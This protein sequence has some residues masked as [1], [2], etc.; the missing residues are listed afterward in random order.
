MLCVECGRERDIF[1]NGVCLEC[2]LKHH[3][4]SSGP[5]FIDIPLCVHCGSMRYK[6]TWMNDPLEMV[7]KRWVKHFFYIE[8]DLRNV[9]IEVNCNLD[10]EEIP[11]EITIIGFIDGIEIREGHRVTIRLKRT[12][13]DVCSKRFGGYHEAILQ[14]RTSKRKLSNQEKEDLKKFI[15]EM[16]YSMQEKGNRKLFIA[17]VGEEHGGLD[18]YLS[19]KQVAHA[20]IKKAQDHFGGELKISSKNI[21][22]KNG[23]RIYRMTYLLR[24]FPFKKGDI[25]DLNGIIYMILSFSKNQVHALELSRWKEYSFNSKDIVSATLLEGKYTRK[26]MIVVNQMEDEIQVMDPDNYE[27]FEIK[28]PIEG[29]IKTEMVPILALKDRLYIIPNNVKET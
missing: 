20:I 19:D 8:R 23:R 9:S 13:C 17:D 24:L 25:I 15:E 7:L 1:R 14:L 3:S 21:G 2:Y 22:M 6:S 18:F 27:L 5:T 11:C 16:V 12:V 26:K 10:K 28:K 4:F 29:S